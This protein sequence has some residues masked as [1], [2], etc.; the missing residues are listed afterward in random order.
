MKLHLISLAL[1]ATLAAPAVL[2]ADHGQGT[3]HQSYSVQI[4]HPWSRP[5][6][7]GTAMGVGYLTI[8]NHGDE[9]ITLVGAATPRAGQVSIHESAMHQGVMRMRAVGDGLV[10]P[11]GKTVQLKPRGYHLMLEKL[12]EPLVEGEKIALRLDFNGAEDQDIELLVHSLDG[13]SAV[14]DHSGMEH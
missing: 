8:T 10:I 3:S 9:A 12:R 4:D 6:P 7:P 2:A 1:A 13:E 14:S 5:T 11:A